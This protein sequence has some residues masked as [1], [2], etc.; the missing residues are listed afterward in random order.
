MAGAPRG[1][2]MPGSPA[3]LPCLGM[4]NV[5]PFLGGARVTRGFLRLVGEVLP[6]RPSLAVIASIAARLG[7][8][9]S[10]GIRCSHAYR[11]CPG[12]AEDTRRDPPPEAGIAAARQP[13]GSR[14]SESLPVAGGS[15]AVPVYSKSWSPSLLVDDRAIDVEAG[16]DLPRY[17][18]VL[19]LGAFG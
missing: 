14:G 16:V 9:G 8:G 7:N 13:V 17:G 12:R 3:N 2:F 19:L 4:S 10:S 11:F 6:A 5:S 18:R 1:W 15:D